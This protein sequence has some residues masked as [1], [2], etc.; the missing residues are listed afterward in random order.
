LRTYPERVTDYQTSTPGYRRFMA[1]ATGVVGLMLIVFAVI[2][3]VLGKWSTVILDVPL[4]IICV[5]GY[6]HQSRKGDSN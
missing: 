2:A 1:R 6:L 4:A 3:V 5:A